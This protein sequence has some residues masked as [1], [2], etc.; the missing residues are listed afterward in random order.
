MQSRYSALEG[1]QDQSE[2][3]WNLLTELLHVDVVGFMQLMRDY[4]AKGL[5]VAD[6]ESQRATG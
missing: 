3:N 1:I 4:K 2:I 6:I 5:N